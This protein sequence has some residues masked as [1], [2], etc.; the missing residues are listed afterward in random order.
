[1][2]NKPGPKEGK[3]QAWN[4]TTDTIEDIV[5]HLGKEYPQEG[6]I[7][8]SDR[9][10]DDYLI[11]L[12]S[13]TIWRILKRTKTRYTREYKR[14]KQD[15][16]LYCLDEPGIELQMDA[17]FPYGRSRKIACFDAIDDCSRWVYAHIYQR[18]D[19]KSAID[20]VNKLVEKAPF[21][22]QR[23][24]VD[25]RYGKELKAHCQSLGIEVITN[26]PYSPQQNGKI[27]RFHK[28]IKREFFWKHCSY[29]DSALTLQFKLYLWLNHYNT[30]RRHQGFGMNKL[31][32]VQKIAQTQLQAL[33]FNLT[34][35]QKVTLSLQQYKG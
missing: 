12:D 29:Q 4:R 14:W 32:P 10:R 1:V 24:R 7:T 9:L 27:E 35:P 31:T 8:L 34:Y 16:I 17:C 22:I 15:P 5:V 25:N 13:T 30:K 3:N 2:P 33:S 18:E 6:P 19:A 28:S 23:I 20:F 26:E 11:S 21:R